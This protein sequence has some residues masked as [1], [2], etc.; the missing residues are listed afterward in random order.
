MYKLSKK[1]EKSSDEIFRKLNRES[2]NNLP[3]SQLCNTLRKIHHYEFD[4]ITE[5]DCKDIFRM[6]D[7]SSE[8]A[9]EISYEAFHTFFL[10]LQ[11]SQKGDTNDVVKRNRQATKMRN[12]MK[13]EI[14]DW[15]TEFETKNGRKP[16]KEERK[17][18][19]DKFQALE[20]VI[21]IYI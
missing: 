11:E 3:V 14:K 12:S 6:I 10:R 16:N 21:N 7:S 2:Y 15:M 17:E 19:A 4:K 5:E 1:G 20:E 8:T 13:K 18:I 9:E